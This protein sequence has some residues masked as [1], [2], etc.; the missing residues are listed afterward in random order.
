MAKIVIALGGNALGNTPKEQQDMIKK[1]VPSIVGLIKQGHEVV[2]SHGNGPQVGMIQLAFDTANEI[3]NKVAKFELPECTAMSQGY[4]GYHLQKGLKKE[5]TKQGLKLNVVGVITQIEV[6]KNDDAF[7]NPTKP[8]G[9]FYSK[10]N[11]DKLVQENPSLIFKEDAGR[12]YRQMVASPRP[13]NIVE[14]EAIVELVDNKFVVVACGG[15]GIPVVK[16]QNGDYEGIPAVIDKDF[17]SAK[18]AELIDADY[19]FILTAVDRVAINFG[20]ENE[21]LLENITVDEASK[22]AKEGHFAPGS[23]LP[24]VQAAMQFVQ[25]K[26]ERRAVIA[27]LEKAP[28]AMEGKSGTTIQ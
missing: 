25:S 21:E 2:I 14:K 28:L 9:S 11:A 24:K 20:K 22:Y 27:S 13:I 4:I 16:N 18:L 17:A 23:M 8:I 5:L 6:D 19:L 26:A 15:G 10:E 3:N 1:G 7:K 12:G